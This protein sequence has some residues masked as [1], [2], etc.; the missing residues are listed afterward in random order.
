MAANGQGLPKAVK[1]SELNAVMPPG[2]WQACVSGSFLSRLKKF[3]K[4][5]TNANGDH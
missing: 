5:I 3:Y 2:F 4:Q 1:F